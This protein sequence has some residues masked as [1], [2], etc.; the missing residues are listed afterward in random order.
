MLAGP[1]AVF[2]WQ[3][4]D[5]NL[6]V[7]FDN[8]AEARIDGGE[9]EL[10]WLPRPE[11]LVNLSYSENLYNYL[12]FVDRDLATQAIEQQTVFIDRTEEPLSAPG[13]SVP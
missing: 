9:L 4:S 5:Y 12:E 8:V 2:A 3:E 7:I 1:Q 10:T 6:A 13:V 11:W